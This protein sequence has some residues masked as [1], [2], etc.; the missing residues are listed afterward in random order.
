MADQHAQ[1]CWH[2]HVHVYGRPGPSG[3]R[4][5]S[6]GAGF[7][8]PTD[9][10][11]GPDG[12]IHVADSGNHRIRRISP[13]GK[14]TTIAGSGAT[15]DGNGGYEGDGTIATLARLNNPSAIYTDPSGSIYI[16]DSGN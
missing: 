10:A 4:P 6:S 3:P 2:E 14:I 11:V 7:F 15:G 13:D 9:I 5:V 8:V 16:T 1:S 12:T